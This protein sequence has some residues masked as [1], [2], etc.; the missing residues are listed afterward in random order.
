MRSC[1]L[2]EKVFGSAISDLR[3]GSRDEGDFLVPTFHSAMFC[4][5]S[6]NSIH[7]HA[8][9]GFLLCEKMASELPAIVV[10]HGLPASIVGSGATS[11]FFVTLGKLRWRSPII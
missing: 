3:G 9:S 2:A 4:G 5:A 7:F 1:G 10:W 8:A 11:H 6:R